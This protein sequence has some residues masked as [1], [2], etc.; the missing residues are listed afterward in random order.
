MKEIL[1]NPKIVVLKIAQSIVNGKIMIL[2]YLA[3]KHVEEENVHVQGK[4]P[5][6]HQV[7][8]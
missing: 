7:E 8:D 6:M 3:R 1:R 5:L 2:G 4:R